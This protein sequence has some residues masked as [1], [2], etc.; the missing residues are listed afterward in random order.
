MISCPFWRVKHDEMKQPERGIPWKKGKSLVFFGWGGKRK[1]G[2]HPKK[3]YHSESK[4][5]L[6]WVDGSPSLFG[7]H[8]PVNRSPFVG[9]RGCNKQASSS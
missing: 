3:N 4:N 7:W 5:W 6:V 9:P 2:L 8:F 1:N